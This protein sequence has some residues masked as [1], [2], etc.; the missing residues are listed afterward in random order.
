MFEPKS[1]RL[2]YGDLLAPPHGYLLDGAICTTYSLDLETLI[3]SL[4]A[5]GLNEATDTELLRSPINTLHAIE[6][7]SRKV[8]VFCESGQTSIPPVSSPLY[9][10][11]EMMIVPVALMDK[12][13]NFNYPSFHPKTWIIRYISKDAK[14]LYRFIVLSRNLTFNRNWDMVTTLE[15]REGQGG[16]RKVKPLMDFIAFLGTTINSKDPDSKQKRE[17]VERIVSTLEG[18]RFYASDTGKPFRDFDIIPLGIGDSSYSMI[19]DELF[20]TKPGHGINDIVVMSPF[21]SKEVIQRLDCDSKYLSHS[22]RRVLI[23]RRTELEK[24]QGALKHTDVFVMKD[25]IIDGENEL[26]EEETG[27]SA[28]QQDIHAKAYLSV[29]GS[30]VRFL[31]GSMNASKNGLER[32][33]ELMIRLYTNRHYLNKES[34]IRDLMGGDINDKANPFIKVDPDSI[35]NSEKKEV[36]QD[37]ESIIKRLCRLKI[38]G[39]ITPVDDRYNVTLTCKSGNIPEGIIISPLMAKGLSR[40]FERIVSFS[41]LRLLE[42]S[43]FYSISISDG[44]EKIEKLIL[45]PT[46]GL[47]PDREKSIITDIISDKR[48]FAEYVAF[49][50]GDTSEQ[51]LT[52]MMELDNKETRSIDSRIQSPLTALYERMLRVACDNPERLKDIGRIVKLIDDEDIVT[53][54]FKKM[55]GT[56][57]SALKYKYNG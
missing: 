39:S 1:D 25:A 36:V 9:L 14:P 4:V 52:D 47:P 50:L 5:L 51:V 34:F 10:L 35:P 7:V 46:R 54:E 23:T 57:M 27:S 56:F 32:N 55:Y 17:I 53:P 8:I 29:K 19:D 16:K 11:F 21:I 43:E 38:T 40:P 26:S 48:K 30:D 12:S 6:R 42:L 24:L 31:I 33:V 45:I 44:L 13:G 2:I 28:S 20:N 18:V 22:S 37:N 41:G 49:V 3:A 15:G